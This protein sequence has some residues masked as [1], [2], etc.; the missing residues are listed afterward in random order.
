MVNENHFRF[1]RKSFFNFLKTIYG[2]KT[3]NRFPKL[4][5]SS[6]H[7]RLISDCRNSATS[8]HQ[9]IASSGIRRHLA[10][11]AGCWRPD[12]DHGQKPAG[13]SQNGLDPV[14]SD[15]IRRNSARTQPFWP[16]PVKHA[17]RNLATATGRCRIPATIVF[18]PF[19]IFSCEPNAGKYFIE[20]HFFWK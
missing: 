9:N 2:F 19:V 17:C 15:Q 8:G 11:V 16:D 4:N 14:R 20:N 3:V 18:S 6:L 5:S 10:T 13:S 12:S 1:D 7:T